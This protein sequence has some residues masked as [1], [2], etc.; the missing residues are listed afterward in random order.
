MNQNADIELNPSSFDNIQE[1]KVVEEVS[2]IITGIENETLKI[3]T[4]SG[5]GTIFLMINNVTLEIKES[6]FFQLTKVIND[7]VKKLLKIEGKNEL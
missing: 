4:W 3:L 1:E 5:T 2:S 7:T 6:D